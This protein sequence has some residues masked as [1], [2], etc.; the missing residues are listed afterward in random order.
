MR[1]NSKRCLRAAILGTA[2]T[3]SALSVT[4]ALA[5]T[6]RPNVVILYFDDMGYSDFGLND[7]SQT[8]L[9]P[10]LDALAAE[11]M[12]FTQ[13]YSTDAVCTPS[14]Y[15]LITGRYSWRTDLKTGVTNAYSAPVMDEDRFTIGHMLQSQGYYTAAIGKWHLGMQF[16]NHA[17]NPVNLGGSRVLFDNP[18]NDLIDFSQPLSRTPTSNGFDYY[19]SLIHI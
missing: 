16:H 3:C 1:A 11:G 2:L 17:G 4:S 7:Q 8:S 18:N 12:N 13:A 14:R 15:S 19:L 6:T 9:T 10:R 5:D